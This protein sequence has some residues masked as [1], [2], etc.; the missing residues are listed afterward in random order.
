MG[1]VPPAAARASWT[2]VLTRAFSSDD[3]MVIVVMGSP[4]P[5]VTVVGGVTALAD[6]PAVVMMMKG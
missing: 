5:A 4:M 2:A 1:G 3:D 6:V